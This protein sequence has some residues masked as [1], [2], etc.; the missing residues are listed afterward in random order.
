MLTRG[1]FIGEIVDAFSDLAGQLDT[2]GRL[3]LTDLNIHIESFLKTCLNLLYGL[4]LENLNEERSNAPGLDLGDRTKGWAFQIT[5]QRSTAKVNETLQAITDEHLQAYKGNIRIL[6]AGRKQTRYTISSD[7]K[8]RA[9]FAD[10]DIW[11]LDD[12]CRRCMDLPIDTLQ[13][14]Y[15]HVQSEFA[16][17]KIELEVPDDEGRFPTSVAD[18]VEGVAQPKLSDLRSLHATLLEEGLV[19]RRSETIKLVTELSNNLSRLPRITRDFLAAMIAQSEESARAGANLTI[20]VNV[21]IFDRFVR[22]PDKEGE[23]RILRGLGFIDLCDPDEPGLS[24]HWRVWLPPMNSEQAHVMREFAEERNIGLQQYL[25][26]LDF[27]GF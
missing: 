17:V 25:V 24:Y 11:D 18:F 16:R 26:S 4:A 14:L 6:I 8:N 13:T 2:R 20:L 5:S 10:T 1:H 21:D 12:L 23:L 9:I 15:Q 22:Y 27:S 19:S 3:G 7:L